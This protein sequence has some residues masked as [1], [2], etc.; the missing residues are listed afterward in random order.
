MQKIINSTD[1]AILKAILKRAFKMYTRRRSTVKFRLNEALREYENIFAI[2]KFRYIGIIFH[3]Y[4]F[5][6]GKKNI[7]L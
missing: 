1:N 3:L 5:F 7:S 4:R 6:W 2:I